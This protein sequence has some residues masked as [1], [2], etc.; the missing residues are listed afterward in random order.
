MELKN[1]TEKILWGLKVRKAI[2]KLS[3]CTSFENHI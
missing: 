1:S 2:E 3:Y